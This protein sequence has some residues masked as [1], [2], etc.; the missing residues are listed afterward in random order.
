MRGGSRSGAGR[1]KVKAHLKKEPYNTK[2]PQWII[3]WLTRPG[4]DE[5]GPVMIEKALRA[6]Y[7]IEPT[8]KE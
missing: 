1:K 5:S 7:K 4:R 8:D 2:L 6:F 3:D